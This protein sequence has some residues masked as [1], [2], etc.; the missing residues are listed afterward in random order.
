MIIGNGDLAQAIPD[1]KG[2]LFFASGVSDSSCT[3]EEE[4]QREIN[5]LMEQPKDAHIVYF[6]SLGLL[7]S[8]GTSRYYRHK[9]QMETLVKLN[10]Q[11]YTIIRIGNISWGTNPHTLINYLKAHPDAELKDEYR[12][13][14]DK[15]EFYYWLKRIPVWSCE[16]NII[17]ERMRVKDVYRQY[18]APF[19]KSPR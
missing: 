4:Y 16:M 2:L 6:S 7:E 11:T 14:C 17:G 12:Y 19:V 13:I 3:D 18:V 9:Y 10:F 15:D 5:L 8:D 1:K